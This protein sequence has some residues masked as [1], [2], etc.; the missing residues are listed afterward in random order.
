MDENAETGRDVLTKFGMSLGHLEDLST[1]LE[2]GFSNPKGLSIIT[3]GLVVLQKTHL[4]MAQYLKYFQVF[5]TFVFNHFKAGYC[6]NFIECSLLPFLLPP[7][8]NIIGN[9][10]SMEI[11]SEL[12]YLFCDSYPFN[13]M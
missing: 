9:G 6:W 8:F 10:N 7:T 2:F 4:I 1:I 11:M 5:K 13:G 3:G 12:K